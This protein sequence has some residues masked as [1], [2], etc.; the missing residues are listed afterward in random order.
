[1]ARMRS[2][3]PLRKALEISLTRPPRVRLAQFTWTVEGFTKV[4]QL[5]LYS[6]VFQSGQYNWR[7]LL[8]PNG[9][10]V[11][12]LSVYL[13]V[14]DSVTLPQG[15]S[16]Q[17]HFSLTVQNHKDPTKSVVKGA[18]LSV[19]H[20]RRC[21]PR[22]AAWSRARPRCALYAR[23]RRWR[24]HA[25]HAAPRARRSCADADH[26]FTLR[27]CDWGFRE[28]VQLHELR[29]PRSGYI[30]DDKLIISARVRVEPQVNW[31]NWD[32]KRETGYV[33]LKNQ[34]AT[35]YM[36]SLLQTLYHI[37]YAHTHESRGLTLAFNPK[38]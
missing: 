6:P 22:A 10:N 25:T 8:F 35:C 3:M 2:Q 33:G 4:K 21:S 13:D 23:R 16:R 20:A 37:P 31:W 27:A 17:A 5:K 7:I 14:A 24:T 26:H 12:Q 38:P 29:D 11:Q 9:N 34:G 36:N 19:L 1:M 28:F 32:S 30:N 18:R 15:W